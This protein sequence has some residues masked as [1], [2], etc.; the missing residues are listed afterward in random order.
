MAVDD[1]PPEVFAAGGLVQ[2]AATDGTAEVLLVHRPKYDDWSFPKGKLDPGESEAD[3]ARREVEEET[4]FRCTLGAEAATVRY[5]DGKG[6]RK[7]VRYWHM[8]VSGG[9]AS[10]PNSEVDELRWCAPADASTLLS[11]PHD[12]ALARQ[13]G[14]MP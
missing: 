6:R 13:L 7:Q 5:V 3:A 12:R 11:Y 9:V 4:G 14:A 8:T 2:R 10:V 1:A